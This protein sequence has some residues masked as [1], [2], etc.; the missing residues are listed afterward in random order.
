MIGLVPGR[1]QLGAGRRALAS[2]VL[3]ALPACSLTPEGDPLRPRS[4]TAEGEVA[5]TSSAQGQGPWLRLGRVR[6]AEH[7][8]FRIA[9]REGAVQ[10]HYERRRWSE[11]PVVYLERA[12][13]RQLYHQEG[14][15]RAL[16][17][18]HPTLEVTLLGWE[19][20]KGDLD[21][22]RV[23]R[24]SAALGYVL[25]LRDQVLAEGRLAVELPVGTLEELEELDDPAPRSVAAL[26]LALRQAVADLAKLVIGKLSS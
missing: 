22:G 25:L 3:L 19:E 12:L 8:G 13:V 4:F 10:G 6:A 2:L 9:W 26:S 23:P 17:P 21:E 7:L 15:R 11:S 18:G 1:C 14:L 24:A 5:V 16:T 20:L